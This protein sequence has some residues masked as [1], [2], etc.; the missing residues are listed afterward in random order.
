MIDEHASTPFD[1]RS[2]VA[3]LGTISL[4]SSIFIRPAGVSP[5]WMSMNTTGRDPDVV[6]ALAL[7]VKVASFIDQVRYRSQRLKN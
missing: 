6:V 7:I 4:K 3:H 2:L 5:I 1:P